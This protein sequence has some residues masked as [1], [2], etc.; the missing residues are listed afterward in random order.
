[1]SRP[2][3][4]VANVATGL[5][6]IVAT[7]EGIANANALDPVQATAFKMS[8]AT[9]PALSP[10]V[11][12]PTAVVKGLMNCMI[13]LFNAIPTL[14]TDV[15]GVDLSVPMGLFALARGLVAAMDPATAMGAFAAAADAVPDASP[16]VTP[17]AN[18]L[19]D[20][21]NAQIIARLTRGVLL[22][23]YARALIG[24]TFNARSDAV[25]ARA[26]CVERFER[27]LSLCQGW[28]DAQWAKALSGTRDACVQYL[29][30]TIINLKPIRS[31]SASQ[32][33]PALWWAQRLYQDPGRAADLVARN[34]VAHA[35]YFPLIFEALAN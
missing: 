17:T 32:S 7:L 33:M 10:T 6:D 5:Q 25:T 34:D 20:A 13:G 30:Q 12:A 27:E 4:V 29:S 19:A 26:D 24:V 8:V 15:T 3:W 35:S 22:A 28:L 16:A 2:N 11:S 18:R 23:G 1:M 9:G 21:A 14:T 31:V